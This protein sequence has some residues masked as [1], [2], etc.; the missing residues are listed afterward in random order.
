MRDST[1][2]RAAGWAEH[3]AGWRDA[4]VRTSGR[5][6]AH[7]RFGVPAWFQHGL[8]IA[9]REARRVGTRLVAR[10]YDLARAAVVVTLVATIAASSV[11]LVVGDARLLAAEQARH[12]LLADQ[13]RADEVVQARAA[14]AA[15]AQV[16]IDKAEAVRTDA[17]EAAVPDET[18]ATL[19]AATAQVQVL[20]EQVYTAPVSHSPPSGA[21]QPRAAAPT[22]SPTTTGGRAAESPTSDPLPTGLPVTSPQTLPDLAADGAAII[23]VVP[24]AVD[25][26]RETLPE[27]TV[28]D[29]ALV[30]LLAAVDQLA[31][32]TAEVAAAAE[33]NRVAAE[34]QSTYEQAV[35]EAEA[36]H[37]AAQAAASQSRAARLRADAHSL[38]GY[39]N[40]QV[41]SSALCAPAFS[42][43]AR[44]RCDA[45]EMLD[46]LN[47][48]YRARFGR[49]LSVTD[50]YR[51]LNGQIA[52]RETKGSLCANPG[53]SKHGLGLAVDLGGPE[54]RIGTVEHQ[55][56]LDHVT[57]YGWNKPNWSLP[58]GS[59]PEPWH[60]E[61]V[62]AP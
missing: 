21:T 16:A 32:S 48:A 37:E 44:L 4:A 6:V 35:A 45:A 52:C 18:L 47:Q 38:D 39:S 42:L 33:A 36:A 10:R 28:D 20:V 31:E 61:F 27:V 57:E 50:S 60:F 53:T 41:P 43:N 56:M 8:V 55:W 58:T 49:N 2:R 59:K 22:P 29:E 14:A 5:F 11:G 23:D 7:D 34:L 54:A 40:G 51:T 3:L 13:A 24:T 25:E 15:S 62:G 46:G 19:D 30:Q 12:Q 17:A 1:T 26:I 9:S